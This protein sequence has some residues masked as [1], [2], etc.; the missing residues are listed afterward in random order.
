MSEP[1]YGEI[2]IFGFGYAPAHW[3]NCD[4]QLMPIGQ[5]QALYALLGT[6]YGGDGYN[7]PRKLDHKLR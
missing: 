1:F 7:E 6:T 5:H 3:A 2:R 4:G